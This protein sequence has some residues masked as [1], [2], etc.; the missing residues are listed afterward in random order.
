MNSG[1]KTRHK[2]WK[3]ICGFNKHHNC[4]QLQSLLQL[5]FCG[6]V[7]YVEAS[8]VWTEELHEHNYVMKDVNKVWFLLLLA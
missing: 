7:A 3:F 1:H 8:T 2:H 4:K 5:W 6:A